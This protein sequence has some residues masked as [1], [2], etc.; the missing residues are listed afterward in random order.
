MKIDAFCHVMPQA[1]AERLA[2]LDD[3]PAAANI[4]ERIA[5]I[6]SLVDLDLRF[7]QMDEFGEDYRQIIS[8][9]APPPEDLGDPR[10]SRDMARLGNEGLAELVQRH[11]DRFAGWVAALPLND[12]D[13]ADRGARR[14]RSAWGRSARRCTRNVN[15]HPPD[16]ER[17]EPFYA[18]D[19]RA[20]TG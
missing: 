2:G 3:T 16:E 7:R 11:P 20:A 1:Y 4:R 9:P 5:N 8:L 13:A 12:P 17:F 6:P 18:R 15:G 19:G 10:L 14:A